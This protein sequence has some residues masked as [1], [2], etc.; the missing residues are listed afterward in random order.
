MRPLGHVKTKGASDRYNPERCSLSAKLT[1]MNTKPQ[2]NPT[3][4]DPEVTND[5]VAAVNSAVA[6]PV[7]QDDEQGSGI[8]EEIKAIDDRSGVN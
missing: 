7:V 3:S 2:D 4:A 5:V 8:S 6:Q 1:K